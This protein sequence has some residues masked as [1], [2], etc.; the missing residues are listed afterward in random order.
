M[1]IDKAQRDAWAKLAE[2]VTF[3]CDDPDCMLRDCKLSRAVIALLAELAA[4]DAATT[5]W[6]R[7][8]EQMQA[9]LS[10]GNTATSNVPSLYSRRVLAELA[11]LLASEGL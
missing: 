2:H 4:A 10:D 5:K 1:S 3:S 11:R 8:I 6:Q 9:W 7:V